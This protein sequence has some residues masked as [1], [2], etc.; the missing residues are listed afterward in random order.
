[1]LRNTF[2]SE[3]DAGYCITGWT[4]GVPFLVGTKNGYS[5]LGH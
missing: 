3:K 2:R 5:S 4:T 1:M